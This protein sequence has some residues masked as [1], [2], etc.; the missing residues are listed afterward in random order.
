ML[1]N[2]NAAKISLFPTILT[3]L[4]RANVLNGHALVFVGSWRLVKDC[5]RVPT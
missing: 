3:L 4:I 1:V 2:P 5:F